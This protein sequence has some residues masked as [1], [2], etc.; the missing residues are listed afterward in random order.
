MR[1]RNVY[2][3]GGKEITDF[4]GK[5]REEKARQDA[6]GRENVDRGLWN[7]TRI[8]LQSAEQ[9]RGELKKDKT[10]IVPALNEP[11]KRRTKAEREASQKRATAAREEVEAKVPGTGGQYLTSEQAAAELK[12]ERQLKETT[13]TVTAPEPVKQTEATT[14]I[15]AEIVSR[16]SK[17]KPAAATGAPVLI[18]DLRTEFSSLGKEAFD[19][20]MLK[21]A[22]QGRIALHR[23]DHAASLPEAERDKLVKDKDDYFIAATITEQPGAAE[24]KFSSTQID[25]PNIIADKILAF[26][27]RI[28]LKTA[29]RPC[30]TSQSSMACMAPI[31]SRLGRRSPARGRSRSSSARCRC[32]RTT[33]LTS[34]KSTSKALT[35]TG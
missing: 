18:S 4:V 3:M 24:H 23:H 13:E 12:A 8:L 22:E 5:L 30:R 25:L 27:T 31:R 33:M 21:L 7:T 11:G 2:R 10:E 15:G 17:I 34:S 14:D 1:N 35:F 20:E 29:A 6:A 26:P 9:R 16:I 28:L 32:L 19:A